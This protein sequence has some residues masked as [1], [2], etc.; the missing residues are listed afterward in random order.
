MVGKAAHVADE[1][2]SA[3]GEGLAHAW[4]WFELHANQRMTMLRFSI[5]TLSGVGAAVGVLLSQHEYSLCCM[6]SLFGVILSFSFIRL[7]RR[8]SKLVKLGENALASY[9]DRLATITDNQFLKICT[10][11]E[12]CLERWPSSYGQIFRLVFL[13]T[14]VGFA[15]ICF[16]DCRLSQHIR[17]ITNLL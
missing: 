14:L 15:I 3:Y 2:E 6:I 7:D 13:S 5:L 8:T 16:L 10:H 1:K 4:A 9:Q 11:S 17:H 12:T